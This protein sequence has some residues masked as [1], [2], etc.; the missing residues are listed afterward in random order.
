MI[1]TGSF[2]RTLPPHIRS[3]DSIA[4][5][6][7]PKSAALLPVLIA[8][9]VLGGADFLRTL[10]LGVMSVAG[11]D[12]LG[13]GFFRRKSG[14]SNGDAVFT[15]LIFAL[16]LPGR[17]P[18][19]LII[20]GAFMVT[21]IINECFGGLGSRLFNAA[22]FGRV[23][24]DICFPAAMTESF[25]FQNAGNP[26]MLG[27]VAASAVFFLVQ[28][29]IYFEAPLLFAGI[30]L[31]V[32]VLPGS[33][34]GFLAAAGTG[35]FSAGFLLSDNA[36]LP[37]TR[38]GTALFSAA[39]ALLAVLFSLGGPAAAAIACAVLIMNGLA[40]WIDHWAKNKFAGGHA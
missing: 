38:R 2:V 5:R 8:A 9:G 7:W 15:G 21:V 29:K 26:W 40:P 1:K 31:T 4:K 36:T 12:W 11:F 39:A 34:T 28:K 3:A 30:F 14:L 27:A 6:Y 22:L 23:F 25:I 16:L 37:I 18:S 35:V 33:G 10:T 17:C 19:A 13:G 20:L 32:A 24:L